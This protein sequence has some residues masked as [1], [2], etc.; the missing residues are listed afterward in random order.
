V[1]GDR[2]SGYRSAAAELVTGM[3]CHRPSVMVQVGSPHRGGTPG[4]R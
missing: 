1:F 2:G 3:G 4:G